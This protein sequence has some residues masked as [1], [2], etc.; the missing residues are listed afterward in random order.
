MFL[1]KDVKEEVSKLI[2]LES[3]PKT[4]SCKEEDKYDDGF[5]LA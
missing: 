1:P 3:F 5:S 4:L 2:A